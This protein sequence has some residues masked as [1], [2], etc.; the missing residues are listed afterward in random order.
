MQLAGIVL[1]ERRKSHLPNKEHDF[2]A[3]ILWYR[4]FSRLR[5]RGE[6]APKLRQGDW[7]GSD[8]ADQHKQKRSPLQALGLSRQLHRCGSGRWPARVVHPIQTQNLT[9]RRDHNPMAM[10]EMFSTPLPPGKPISSHEA[11]PR[12]DKARPMHAFILARREEAAAAS[13]HWQARFA[14]NRISRL[15]FQSR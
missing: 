11:P 6:A 5:D 10:E 14:G 4:T 12:P 3:N 8:G 15:S 7:G 1:G 9:F 13:R 2:P